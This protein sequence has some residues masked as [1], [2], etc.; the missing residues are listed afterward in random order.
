MTH[1]KLLIFSSLLITGTICL[2]LLNN[3]KTK[4]ISLN[5]IDYCTNKIND[6]NTN[7]TKSLTLFEEILW[8][9]DNPKAEVDHETKVMQLFNFDFPNIINTI[10][11][12]TINDRTLYSSIAQ[13]DGNYETSGNSVSFAWGDVSKDSKRSVDW[14]KVLPNYINLAIMHNNTSWQMNTL[15]VKLHTK[16]IWKKGDSVSQLHSKIVFQ[17]GNNSSYVYNN[18]DSLD[19]SFARG[20]SHDLKNNKSNFVAIP[21]VFAKEDYFTYVLYNYTARFIYT[22]G[23]YTTKSTDFNQDLSTTIPLNGLFSTDTNDLAFSFD[24]SQFII[25]KDVNYSNNSLEF[26]INDDILQL[27]DYCSIMVNEDVDSWISLLAKSIFSSKT[28]GVNYQDEVNACNWI[29]QHA[30]D[31]HFNPSNIAELKNLT[32]FTQIKAKL[33]TVTTDNDPIFAL[34]QKYGFHDDKRV[35]QSIL[36][37]E[38]YLSINL[39][40]TTYNNSTGSYE[41]N[42]R[43]FTYNDFINNN[44]NIPLQKDPNGE[45]YFK[46]NDLQ[47]NRY[48]DKYVYIAKTHQNWSNEWSSSHLIKEDNHYKLA[49]PIYTKVTYL[50]LSQS[51]LNQYPSSITKEM[52]INNYI[53]IYDDQGNLINLPADQYD[54]VNLYPN[55]ILG[56]LTVTVKIDGQTSGFSYGDLKKF[57]MNQF[58]E[59]DVSPYYTSKIASDITKQQIINILVSAGYDK[60]IVDNS[61]INIENVDDINGTITIDISETNE[62]NQT[63]KLK[64]FS[65][66]K[67]EQNNNPQNT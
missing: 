35:I 52:I 57:D 41:E 60:S 55:D 33:D 14:T 15:G 54:I 64:N 19:F 22:L 65:A 32:T 38:K 53:H 67:L 51:L 13:N 48:K 18:E 25:V 1:K 28:E 2:P 37:L 26:G 39:N 12:T 9:K 56:R 62:L 47:T 42:I 58:S 49:D 8:H 61:A 50:P 63:I 24:P 66:C 44:V 36:A 16:L 29:L 4:A 31:G 30:H 17:N 21:Y 3:N 5:S 20:L 45:Y 59:I 40:Y 6:F 34:Y 23:T 43:T 7:P 46:V 27:Y 11:N 10:S